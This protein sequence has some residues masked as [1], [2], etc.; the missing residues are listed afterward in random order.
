VLELDP[1]RVEE[2]RAAH[3]EIERCVEDLRKRADADGPLDEALAQLKALVESHVREEESGLFP[4]VEKSDASDL[5]T[6][7]VALI[8]RK[9]QLTGSTRSLEAPAT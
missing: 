9:E 1:K 4:Q 5:R 7:G 2:A 3:S 8:E 6:L